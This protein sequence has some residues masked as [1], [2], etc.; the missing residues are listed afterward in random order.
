MLLSCPSYGSVLL[1]LYIVLFCP[2]CYCSV[3]ATALFCSGCTQLCSV[4]SVIVL[5]ELRFCTAQAVH[6]SVLSD[7][8]LS[9]PSYGSVLLKLCI[10]LFCPICY[11]PVRVTVLYCSSCTQ[12]CSVRSVIVL[13]K[14]RSCP[15]QAVHSSVLSDLLL[16]CPSY[17]SVLLKLYIGLFY[18]ICYCPVRATVLSSNCTQFCSVRS[19]IVLSKLWFCTAQAVHRSVLSDLLLSCPNCGFVLLKL[20]I[21]LFCPICYCLVQAVVLSCSSCTQ[22]CSVRSVIVLSKLWFCTAQAVH[23]SVLSDLLL[24]CPSCGSVLIKL[25]IVLFCPI[26]YC[27]VRATA[28]SCSSCTQFYSVR[29]VIVLSE[30]RFCPPQAVHSS[31]LSDLLLFCP[32]CGSVLLKLYI[33]LF[34]PICYCPVQAVVLYCSSCTQLCSVRSVIVLSELRF[35]TAQAV[36]SSVLSYLLSSCPSYGSVLLKLCI[37]LFYPI[38]YCPVRAT[39]LY[40]SSCT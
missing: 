13:S 4:R 16:S 29:S 19:V 5:S 18:P 6:S 17:G 23:S 27:P 12:F 40:C 37:V 10:V 9:C 14:L 8:L 34:C 38:C 26:C 21:V 25:Y 1:K 30:Q 31:V 35:C 33:V 22:F 11:C 7:L 32:S 36:Y 20:C 39:V 3:R 2:I 15:A 28:L 24:S